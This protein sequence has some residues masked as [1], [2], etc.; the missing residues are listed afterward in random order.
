M[1]GFVCFYYF[2]LRFRGQEGA[3]RILYFFFHR[4]KI[5][6]TNGFIKK[7]SRVPKR[8]ILTAIERKKNFLGR[9]KEGDAL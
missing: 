1:A 5:I 3:I 2:E 8:E 7:S 4:D 9:Q 6:F